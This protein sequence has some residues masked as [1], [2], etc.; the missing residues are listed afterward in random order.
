MIGSPRGDLD[1]F[2]NHYFLSSELKEKE[3]SV[4][5]RKLEQKIEKKFEIPSPAITSLGNN[6]IK[7]MIYFTKLVW[8]YKDVIYAKVF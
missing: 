2:L 5:E 8:K 7:I 6:K 3:W 1:T 4:V